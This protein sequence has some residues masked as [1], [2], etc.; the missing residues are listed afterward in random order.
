MILVECTYFAYPV[1][2]CSHGVGDKPISCKMG[3]AG[4]FQ[5]SSSLWDETLI[6]GSKA[7]VLFTV[8]S[9][10]LLYLLLYLDLCVL[11]DDAWIS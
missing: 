8:E 1:Q 5:A 6:K 11:G 9:L 7:A 2:N 10:S 4:R 3:V